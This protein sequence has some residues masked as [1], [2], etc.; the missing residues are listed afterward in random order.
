[1]AKRQWARCACSVFMSFV[2]AFGVA[3]GSLPVQWAEAA[4]NAVEDAAEAS[5]AE[6]PE[7]ELRDVTTEVAETAAAE[8]IAEMLASKDGQSEEAL[9]QAELIDVH[10]PDDTVTVI[11]QLQ[12]SP[13]AGGAVTLL[14]NW[15]LSISHEAVKKQIENIVSSDSSEGRPDDGNQGDLRLSA[16]SDEPEGDGSDADAGEDPVFEVLYD[17]Y[18]VLNGMAV[19]VKYRY[20][21]DIRSI[22]GVKRAFVEAVYICEQDDSLAVGDF[23]LGDELADDG[24]DDSETTYKNA[25][26]LAMVGADHVGYTGKGQSIAIIDS[27][28]DVNHEA[29]SAAAM[30]EEVAYTQEQMASIMNGASGELKAASPKY[31]NAKIPYAWDYADNDDNVIPGTYTDLSHGTHVAGIAA[32]NGGTTIRGVAPDAQ[33]IAMKTF[34]DLRGAGYQSNI[35]AA[36]EDAYILGVD[37]MNMSLGTTA[38]F[39]VDADAVT[40]E[41]YANVRAAGITCNV[42]AGN[43]YS[44]TYGNVDGTNLPAAANPDNSIIASPATYT[45]AFSVASAEGGTSDYFELADGS[46]VKYRE[47]TA[48]DGDKVQLNTCSGTF[49]YIDCGYGTAEEIADAIAVADLTDLDGCFALVQ[50]GNVADGDVITFET[51][52]DNAWDQKAEGIVVYDNV[53]ADTLVNM[54]GITKI[55]IYSVFVSKADGEKMR[56]AATKAITVAPAMSEPDPASMSDF[57]SWGVTPDLK[58]KPEISA[59][60]GGIYSSIPNDSYTTMS[61]TSMATPAV[62]G[63]S[64]LVREYVETDSKFSSLTAAQKNDM[65]TNLIMSTATPVATTVDGEASYYSPRKQGA[66]MANAGLA[67]ASRAYITVAGAQDASRP[68]ADLGDS[69]AGSYSFTFTVHNLTDGALSYALDT[70]ALS[71]VIKDGHFQQKSKNYA[72]AGVDVSYTG[73]QGDGETLVVPASGTADVTVSIVANDTFK[74][75]VA[76]AENGTFLDGFV[77]LTAG[78]DCGSSLTVPYLAFYGDWGTPPILE[79]AYGDE[80]PV[81]YM[82]QSYAYSSSNGYYYLGQNMF[83]GSFHTDRYVI[84][85]D[86]LAQTFAGVATCTGL[87]RSAEKLTYTI[88]DAAGNTVKEYSYDNVPKSYYYTS[89]TNTYAEA[90]LGSSPTFDGKRDDGTYVD[91]GIYTMTVKAKVAGKEAYDTWSFDFAFDTQKPTVRDWELVGSEGDQ[92][93]NITLRD[94]HYLS[95]VQVVTSNG[96][97]S[98][99]TTILDEPVVKGDGFNEY[100]LS[101]DYEDLVK[102]L[103]GVDG[104]RTDVVMLDLFDYALN[105]SEVQVP[106]KDT[107]PTKVELSQ[108]EASL[109]K[110]QQLALE[111]TLIPAEV[112]KDAITWTSSNK[113]VATVDDGGVVTAVGAGW[114]C[115]MDT[116]LPSCRSLDQPLVGADTESF[117]YY[118]IDGFIVSEGVEIL[119]LQTQ[120]LGFVNSDHN[121]VVLDVRLPWA[122]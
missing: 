13:G 1:M 38:G 100:V 116:T 12:A 92:T 106:I 31:V 26:S 89:G 7:A 121:P 60:G 23:D 18:N 28:V 87:L 36:V 65:I 19:R 30:P 67:I 40:Q 71:E 15:M 2:L 105:F 34:D 115:L 57:S 16:M 102:S 76:Q 82:K 8:R 96:A 90:F 53:D 68:K 79:D 29:F 22:N 46:H 17:Y 63:V 47:G 80:S 51:K 66:G 24:S 43:A 110:G 10:Q 6:A 84:S 77:R 21:D 56:D 104:A 113:N 59:P 93:L 33:I 20:L 95:A 122:Y 9:K 61:G 48:S 85:P 55:D 108:T 94:N 49:P 99:G 86:S 98:V 50:R 112:T 32:A 101:L 25:N 37:S 44:S 83:D 72:G 11:V 81:Y 27:G 70:S 103:E 3:F 73:L 14:Q 39:S 97:G 88:T 114:Q 91:D 45:Q 42:A 4:E 111:A 35:I 52:V 107:Y 75:A 58:L 119:N 120:D 118:L 54:G 5:E 62:A 69:E 117:Q 74:D 41:V 109:L 64:A 78:P